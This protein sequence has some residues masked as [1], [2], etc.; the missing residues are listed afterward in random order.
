MVADDWD[1]WKDSVAAKAAWVGAV[2]FDSEV[3]EGGA[4]VVMS[5][6]AH[7]ELL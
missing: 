4:P 3:E 5:I 1:T 2:R 6:Q 7:R